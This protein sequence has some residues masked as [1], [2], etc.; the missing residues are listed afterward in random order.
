MPAQSRAAKTAAQPYHPEAFQFVKAGIAHTV[1]ILNRGVETGP[2][3]HVSGQELCIGL[4]DLAI[5]RFG[6]L[7]PQVLG[8]WNVNRTDDFGRIVFALVEKGEL[9]T[10]EGDS[11]E[12]FRGVFEFDEAFARGEITNHCLGRKSIRTIPS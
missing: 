12:D 9:S 10:T 2:A 6:F 11:I 4:R 7:A 1:A 8:F 5:D 3:R